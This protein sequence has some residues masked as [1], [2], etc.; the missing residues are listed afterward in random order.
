MYVFL[1]ITM[2]ISKMYD[3][4]F[5]SDLQWILHDLSATSV[6]QK[7]M[8]R[9]CIY[10]HNHRSWTA[11]PLFHNSHFFTSSSTGLHLTPYRPPTSQSFHWKLLSKVPHKP[12][13]RICSLWCVQVQSRKEVISAIIRFKWK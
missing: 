12:M 3:I 6:P 9:T 1:R 8:L 11:V 4:L 13:R 10:L 5:K 7:R 2:K